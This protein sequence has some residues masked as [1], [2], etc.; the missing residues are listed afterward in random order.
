MARGEGGSLSC[1]GYALRTNGKR[2]LCLDP[3]FL[4]NVAAWATNPPFWIWLLCDETAGSSVAV[5]VSGS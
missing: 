4:T 5:A 3:G 1:G 2:S